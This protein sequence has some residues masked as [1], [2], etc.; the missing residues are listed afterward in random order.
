MSHRADS[1]VPPA[2]GAG[3]LA[4]AG[5]L[6]VSLAAGGAGGVAS[7]SAGDFY[8]QLARPGWAPPSWLFGPVWTLLYVL[9]GI[10]AWLV[11]RER[12]A[13]DAPAR[14]LGLTLFVTQLILNALWTWLFFRW[15][16]GGWAFA[17]LVLLTLL[18]AAT[19]AAFFR[20]RQIAGWMLVPYLAWLTYAGAL[21]WAVWRSNPGLL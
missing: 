18:V 16:L 15:R 17:E 19:A 6:A 11:W 10:A 14:R 9:M 21:N 1:A 12:N 5:W 7:A 8:G 20:V 2:A 3:W 13:A 4:L